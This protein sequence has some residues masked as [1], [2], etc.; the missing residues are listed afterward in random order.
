MKV[1]D[2]NKV[3]MI[4]A[5]YFDILEQIARRVRNSS[6]PFGGIQLVLVGDFL[7]LPVTFIDVAH[8]N[9]QVCV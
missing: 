9:H 1:S 2:V 5:Q 4:E 3:S 6:K 7:Q 8:R